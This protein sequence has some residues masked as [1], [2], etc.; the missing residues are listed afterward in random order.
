MNPAYTIWNVPD[1]KLSSTD[2]SYLKL[3]TCVDDED[4]T[5]QFSFSS[6][7]HSL[8]PFWFWLAGVGF[9]WVIADIRLRLRLRR[10]GSRIF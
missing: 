2:I 7:L 8:F 3:E 5:R 10:T 4:W 9:D 6:I 1:P